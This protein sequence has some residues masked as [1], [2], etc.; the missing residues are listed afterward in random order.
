ML[1]AHLIVAE[2]FSTHGQACIVTSGRDSADG[3]LGKTL[4]DAGL[5]VPAC[6]AR[7]Y[8]S[9]HITDQTIKNRILLELKSRLPFCD[10]L[11]HSVQGGAEH[12]H[13]EVDPKNDPIF[14]AK[15]AAWKNG[16]NVTW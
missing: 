13:I 7:D 2:V 12:F 9:I 3:R 8:S 4:H 6:F 14:Q 15:K 5:N 16:E 10:V 1:E 11:L